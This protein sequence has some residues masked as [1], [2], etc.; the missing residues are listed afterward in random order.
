[1]DRELEELVRRCVCRLIATLPRDQ[2][3]ILW[4]ADIDGQCTTCIARCLDSAPRKVQP[5]LYAARIAVWHWLK[6]RAG[7]RLDDRPTDNER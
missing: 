6:P 7:A 3:E 1:M 5:S 4:R 2:A